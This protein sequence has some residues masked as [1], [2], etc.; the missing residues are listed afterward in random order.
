M[1]GQ[2]VEREQTNPVVN[3][4]KFSP[5]EVFFERYNLSERVGMVKH[6]QLFRQIARSREIDLPETFCNVRKPRRIQSWAYKNSAERVHIAAGGHAAKQR[7]FDQCRSSAHEWIV[8][9]VPRFSES[10]D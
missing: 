2:S 5:Q 9:N 10:L 7:R 3:R 6:Q 8:N 4:V 1:S